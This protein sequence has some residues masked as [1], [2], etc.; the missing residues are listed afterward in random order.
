M[1]S[2]LV[3]ELIL[4]SIETRKS[5]ASVHRDCHKARAWITSL[6]FAALLHVKSARAEAL[7][8]YAL[9]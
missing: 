4:L 1:A 5:T 9:P 3:S 7:A 2:S 6:R 8:I